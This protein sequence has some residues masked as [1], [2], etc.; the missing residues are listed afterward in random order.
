M[1]LLRQWE[2][3]PQSDLFRSVTTMR[4]K[5]S[6]NC[7]R[8]HSSHHEPLNPTASQENL[9]ANELMPDRT[10]Q[11]IHRLLDSGQLTAHILQQILFIVF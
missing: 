2:I 1:I 11:R 9:T 10:H 3:G 7:P 8:I 5:R 4:L 6:K